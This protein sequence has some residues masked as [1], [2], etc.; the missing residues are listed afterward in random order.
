MAAW[1]YSARLIP[2]TLLGRGAALPRVLSAEALESHGTWPD[3]IPLRMLQQSLDGILERRESWHRGLLGWGLEDGNR[4]DVWSEN[5]RVSEVVFR[6]DAR[7]A[8][9]P[10]LSKIVA[11]AGDLGLLI[12]TDA[13]KVFEPEIEQ[14]LLEFH[15]SPA[16][17]FARNPEAYL[18][19]LRGDEQD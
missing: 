17:S 9:R 16:A 13:L 4:V 3:T 6:V 14:I 1:Q 11:L 8:A 18:D 15:R 2:K 5:D 10:F 12:L 19:E 7:G